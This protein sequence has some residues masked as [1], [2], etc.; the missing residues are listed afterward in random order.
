MH[1]ASHYQ[2]LVDRSPKKKPTIGYFERH[3]I[4]P[5]CMNGTNDKNNLV[6][7]TAREHYVAHQLLV[8]MY[9]DNH[10]LIYAA[11][12]MGT[13]SG[14]KMYEWLRIQHSRRQSELMKHKSPAHIRAISL[15]AKRLHRNRPTNL[16]E[17]NRKFMTGLN[18]EP[19]TCPH[20]DKTGQIGAMHRWH[21]DN[22]KAA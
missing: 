14:N 1:Y 3:H 9:P 12:R 20:C 22:C 7:L 8:K 21:F 15:A 6:F 2:R 4:V 11:K 19:V 16:T 18:I 17:A 5:K 13:R 10:N